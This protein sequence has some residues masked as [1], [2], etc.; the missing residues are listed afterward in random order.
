[1]RRTGV[2]GHHVHGD[3]DTPLVRGHD[4]PFDGGHPAEQRIDVTRIGDVVAVVG[5]RRDGDRAEPDRI[6]TQLL[7]I[8]QPGGHAVQIANAVAVGVGE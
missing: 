6:D 7:Q 5:H 2:V 1:M 8:V 3:L 4:Q